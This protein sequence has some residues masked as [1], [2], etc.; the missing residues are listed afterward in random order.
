MRLP[1]RAV[2]V[3]MV[4]A[5][6]TL[7]CPP[8][9]AQDAKLEVTAA[10]TVKTVLQRQTGKRVSVVLPS[11]PELSGVVT[12]VG[13]NVVHLS[14]ISGREFFDAVV[15]LDRISAVVIRARGGAR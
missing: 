11:G 14:E 5:A 7:P 10:D 4:V 12:R 13:D 3:A 1:R 8:A 15:S 9:R 2:L 6:V